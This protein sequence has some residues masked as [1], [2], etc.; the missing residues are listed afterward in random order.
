MNERVTPVSYELAVDMAYLAN[1]KFDQSQVAA[2]LLA[3]A[4]TLQQ[5]AI[6]GATLEVG[7]TALLA[8]R[9]DAAA[10]DFAYASN[11][12][13]NFR[14]EVEGGPSA[15]PAA[16]QAEATSLETLT[17][18]EQAYKAEA[19]K[20]LRLS[21]GSYVSVMEAIN[22]TAKRR[23]GR[24]QN[25]LPVASVAEAQAALEAVLTPAMIRAE[26]AQ[27][28]EFTANPEANSPEPGFDTVFIT[29]KALTAADENAIA[30][31]LQRK[32]PAYPGKSYIYEPLHNESTAHRGNDTDDTETKVVAVRVPRH[33]NLRRGTVDRQKAAI[34]AHNQDPGQ[35][36]TLQTASDLVAMTHIATLIDGGA[37]D[38][39]TE[40][41]NEARFWATHYKDV[42]A[43][44][45]GGVVPGVVVYGDAR[46][47][48][49][50][51]SVGYDGPSR[52]LVVPRV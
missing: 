38:T 36:T 27:I 46:F 52:A 5:A 33:L 30:A 16:H 47:N 12:V 17:P 2:D 51:S 48:R 49:G 1:D 26:R 29:T 19:L 34:E 50:G 6:P 43:A 15:T 11:C 18:E 31:H 39:T 13:T 40:G 20:G 37:I 21:H 14:T 28:A 22:G 44:P 8:S 23:A 4:E 41:Y 35:N 45:Q 3:A 42:L 10:R 9:Y 24:G 7:A 25:K 32:L